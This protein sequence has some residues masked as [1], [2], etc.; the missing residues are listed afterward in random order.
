MYERRPIVEGS[1]VLRET[2]YDA[3]EVAPYAFG[4]PVFPR[5]LQ[6]A[7]EV[8]RG[9]EAMGLRVLGLHWLFARTQGLHIHHPEAAVRRATREYL[10]RLMD[11]CRAPGGGIMVF[12][13]PPGRGLLPCRRPTHAVAR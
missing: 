12:G 9:A 7:P 4:E 11:F 2:G 5:A 3:V 10:V 1:R 13:S 8:R 6:M